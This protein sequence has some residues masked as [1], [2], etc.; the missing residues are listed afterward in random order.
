MHDMQDDWQRNLKRKSIICRLAKRRKLAEFRICASQSPP[1]ANLGKIGNLRLRSQ[2]SGPPIYLRQSASSPPSD[3]RGG[4]NGPRLT[5]S[6]GSGGENSALEHSLAQPS[7]EP[8]A[9]NSSIRTD[10]RIRGNASPRIRRTA[11]NWGIGA[12]PNSNTFRIGRFASKESGEMPS[13]SRQ[14]ISSCI[15]LSYAIR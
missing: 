1:S 3:F 2:A 6:T 4:C 12:L 13:A 14:A 5:P 15:V 7:K 11:P 9:R 10:R 8:A